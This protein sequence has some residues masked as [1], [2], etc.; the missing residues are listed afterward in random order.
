MADKKE[1][2]QNLLRKL[3][4]VDELLKSSSGR[5]WL[6]RFPRKG[7][8]KAIRET[9]DSLRQEILNGSSPDLSPSSITNLIEKAVM[10]TT[11]PRLRPVINATGI[12]IHTNLGRAP[13]SET[14]LENAISVSRGYSNLEY[15]LSQGS[16]GKRHENISWIIREVTGAEDAVVT[17]NNAAAVLLS[18]ASLSKGKEVLVS[19]GELVE[20]GGSFRIPDV[21]AESGAILKEVGTTNKTHLRDYE[22]AITEETGLLL[23]VHQSNFRII[24]FTAEVGI[25]DLVELGKRY[26]LPV[27]FDLGSGCL[28]PLDDAGI[29]GEPLVEDV[30]RAGVDIVTF[31]GDKLLG[32]PQAGIIAGKKE[33]IQKIARHPLMRAVRPDKLTLSLLEHTLISYLD[34]EKARRDIPV[35]RMLTEPVQSIKRRAAKLKRE[36]LK[37]VPE[38]SVKIQVREGSSQAGGGSLPEINLPTFVLSVVSAKYTASEIEQRLRRSEPPVIV[39]I[40]DD[41]LIMDARTIFDSDIRTIADHFSEIFNS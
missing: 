26:G 6:I 25:D 3:P 11:R 2:L 37:S 12:I 24:G 17:N 38:G 41:M 30:I 22:N 5:S 28:I 14:A 35:I 10:T 40:Q 7:V 9:L 4:S 27:M 31:S 18:L 29:R 39:R 23:K 1:N 20:I 8:I 32:G 15:N 34:P 16:R 36:I 13:L 33:Y 21:M 19:R